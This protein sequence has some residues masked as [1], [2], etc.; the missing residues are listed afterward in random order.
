MTPPVT[1]LDD[2]VLP[3]LRRGPL[4][5]VWEPAVFEVS[6][7][8]AVTCVQGLLTN[9]VEKPGPG[10][11][12]YGA[13]LTPKGMIVVDYWVLR[14]G[15]R[16]LMLAEPEGR[17]ASLDL[18]RRQLPPRLARVQDR[19]GALEAVR[20]YGDHAPHALRSV[21]L[22]DPPGPGRAEE[23]E[24]PPGRGVF[25]R[26][27]SAAPF[28]G[29]F[30]MEAETRERLLA[31]LAGHGV[32]VASVEAA[33]AARILAGWPR[34]GREIRDRTL[35]QE[36]RYDEIGGVSYEK[37]C[38]VGQETVA[39]LHFRGHANRGLRGLIWPD[40]APLE[41]ESVLAAGGKEVGSVTSVLE[42]RGRQLGIGMLRREVA[43]GEA[44]TAAGRPARVVP[45]PFPP[46]P[47]VA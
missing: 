38:Y 40:P 41:G 15:D 37:G 22:G 4:A 21:G 24:G 7:P 3:L 35:P 44:V 19:T 1:R 18:F 9:D 16:F 6:G 27:Q 46:E 8:G 42:T 26:P 29:L 39:R 34:L 17:E 36:V 25:A 20:L 12:V 11:L 10:S 45:L 28:Q 30:V 14:L 5:V 13:L 23:R 32:T 43:I 2:T 33:E 31:A 47:L